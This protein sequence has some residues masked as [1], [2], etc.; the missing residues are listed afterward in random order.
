MRSRFSPAIACINLYLMRPNI[1][2]AK[3][4]TTLLATVLSDLPY[5]LGG[6]DISSSLM[7]R[8]SC[9]PAAEVPWS[10]GHARRPWSSVTPQLVHWCA[11][12][13]S[14]PYG[15]PLGAVLNSLHTAL[16]GLLAAC[17]R[18]EL[19][20]SPS[21]SAG[22]LPFPFGSSASEM[23]KGSSAGLWPGRHATYFHGSPDVHAL[24][25]EAASSMRNWMS[26]SSHA[27]WEDA[28]WWRRRTVWRCTTMLGTIPGSFFDSTAI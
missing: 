20:L 21:C 22:R 24:S 16:L 8:L 12:M 13:H 4:L 1:A 2:L 19:P 11:K 26:Y 10:D 18:V 23:S 14:F 7:R 28:L 17:F 6:R 9:L 25:A 5:F 27:S 3:C 15:Q